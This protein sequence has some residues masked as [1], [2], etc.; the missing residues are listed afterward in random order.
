M[1]VFGQHQDLDSPSN[2]SDVVFVRYLHDHDKF[3][4]QPFNYS[5]NNIS[6]NPYSNNQSQEDAEDIFY[7]LIGDENPED[8]SSSLTGIV[9]REESFLTED[10]VETLEANYSK[11]RIIEGSEGE[12]DG[13]VYGEPRHDQRFCYKG[14]IK[15]L[16]SGKD[17]LE[18]LLEND[19][20]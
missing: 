3:L 8:N 10:V 1:D 15:E 11:P 16:E 4:V 5:H 7:R 14:E 17:P 2:E 9:V 18:E 13:L 6:A 19:T 20:R 12:I